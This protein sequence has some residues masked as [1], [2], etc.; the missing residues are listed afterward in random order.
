[1]PQVGDATN[2]LGT[3]CRIGWGKGGDI[4]VPKVLSGDVEAV[5]D[6]NEW[7]RGRVKQLEGL[8]GAILLFP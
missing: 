4:S 2:S 8:L 5:F 6:E 7:L 3:R 1:M